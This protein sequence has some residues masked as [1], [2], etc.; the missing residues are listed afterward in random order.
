MLLFPL[1]DSLQTSLSDKLPQELTEVGV[2][3][4]VK[5]PESQ[6]Q[7]S[8]TMMGQVKLSPKK[9]SDRPEMLA[10]EL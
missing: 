8:Q 1:P 9:L 3:H 7:F 4:K 6:T 5:L 10:T 2:S